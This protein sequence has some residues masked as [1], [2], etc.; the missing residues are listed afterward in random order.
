MCTFIDFTFCG[1]I[2]HWNKCALTFTLWQNGTCGNASNMTM[3]DDMIIV[4][5]HVRTYY[6]LIVVAGIWQTGSPSDSRS[7]LVNLTSIWL[8]LRE[9]ENIK[10]TKTTEDKDNSL[11]EN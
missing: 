5:G 4:H 9:S 10:T 1:D 2:E 7:G 11:M 6:S 3:Y 8:G